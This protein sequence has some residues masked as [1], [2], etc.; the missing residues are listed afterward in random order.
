MVAATAVQFQL[1]RLPL[2]L[3]FCKPLAF[4]F[5]PPFPP[6]MIDFQRLLV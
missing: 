3:S 4:I 2:G 1:G 6:P 5:S